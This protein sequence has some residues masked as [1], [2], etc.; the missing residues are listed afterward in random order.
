MS[1]K[2][3]PISIIRTLIVIDRERQRKRSR[4]GANVVLR[5]IGLALLLTVLGV[6]V[7]VGMGAGTAAAAYS[8]LTE[9]LP[10]PKDVE[11]ASIETF[12]TTKIY[13]WGP[14]RNGDGQRDPELIYEVIDPNAGDRHWVSLS[15]IPE[16]VIC[17]TV[18]AEDKTFWDNPGFNVQGIA[19][20][21]IANLRNEEVQGGSSIT[22]QV[23]KNSVIP[24]EERFQKSY[25]RKIKE[26]LIAIELTRRYDKETILEWYLNTNLYGN[27]AYG[28]DAAAR[29]YFG[30]SASE[31]TLSEAA[32][33]I[34]IPQYPLLNPFDAP[35]AA[36][37]RKNIILQRMVEEGCITSEE[38]AAAKAEPWH[39]AKT[40]QRFDIKAPHF[41][42]YVRRQ[43]E[44]MFGPELVAG[45][46]LRV[47]TTLD[48]EL[49]EQAQCVTQAYLRILQGEDPASVIP[50]AVAAGCEAAQY[51]PD[52][53][54]SRI[55]KDFNI[56]NSAVVAIRPN[57]G[58]ILAMVGSADYW[59]EDIDG[60]FNVA[61]DGLRQPGSSF[62]P[63]T[64]VTFLAQGHNAAHMFLDVRKAFD[65]GPGMPPY[66]PENYSRNYHGPVSLRD[67]LAR[68]LNIPA[69]EA[70]SIA[71]IDNVLRTAHRM[72]ITTLDK[73]LQHYGLSLTLGGGEVKLIDMVYAFSV[74]ANNGAMYGV[75]VPEEDRRPNF[76]E[77]NPIAIL[78]VEDRNGQILYE[79]DQPD[80]K[81]ILD[82]RLAYLITNILSDRKARIPAFGHPNALELANERPAAAKTG[83]TNNFSDNW[84]VGYT[85][86]IVV[87]VWQGNPEGD[88]Y[89]INTP[90]SRGAA[91]I[92]HAVMEYALQDQPI[93]S[94]PR[95]EGLKEVTVCAVS[96]LK[97]N[98]HCPTRTEL[99]I[100]GTEPTEVD[101]LHQVYL[102]NRETGKL[103]TIYTPPEL[104]EERV[105]IILPP[106]AQDWINSLPE[107][108]RAIYQPPTEYDTQYGPN[109]GQADVAIISPTTYSYVSGVV[110]ILG[111]ARN[112]VAFYRL[113]FGEGMNPTQW[114][115][116]GPDHGN[117]VDHNVLEF[118]DTTSLNDGVYTLQLQVVGHDQQLRQ[119][120][121]QL[122]VDNTPPEVDLTYPPEGSEYEY[123]FDEWVNINAEVKDNYA[124]AR[125]EFYQDN[126]E[127]P[128]SI[129]TVPPFNV[130][131]TLQAPGT[132][133]FHVVVYDAAGNKTETEPVR[134]RI[135][136]RKEP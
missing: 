62:K 103:A 84:T 36:L 92:W 96:G 118:F 22:Q 2:G 58:E 27:L 26:I 37:Q 33:L 122:T 81:Q 48:L 129:R 29:V 83:T 127:E 72:G 25:A 77:L 1:N 106:E 95:P 114:L 34:A 78:R 75:P 20:A 69:V 115:Q 68:S 54:A 57:T 40:T 38:A 59:D 120:S 60:K 90:G 3:V 126:S 76:R 4:T 70:M 119:A 10:T 8:A 123:G 35:D 134:I 31:L 56:K 124:V 71:G 28:I 53:P 91:Y 44:E 9:N 102:V 19:R 98:G 131:W 128:F 43:L 46:G 13:A 74:F 7:A 55:G 94:F 112:N 61:A 65:Q 132:Y 86:Q 108:R 11:T 85:P 87:G 63:F 125:V 73:G 109:Q 51:L 50:A 32:T 82:T 79:V 135:I 117:E 64:Y 24:L 21:F 18:A 107:D 121:I 23:V 136:P 80:S 133:Q 110:P 6:G 49:N 93:L 16:Y 42:M 5:I 111:N 130:N 41:S 47:Y 104:V 39:L 88:D 100:P 12:E 113:V 66:V 97:P 30:K 89:M 99:M 14:D 101:T 116:I 52:V 45:G 17:G 67:A 105:Y 15:E